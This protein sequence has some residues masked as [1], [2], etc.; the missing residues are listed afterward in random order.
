[1]Q[2][3]ASSTVAL[4]FLQGSPQFSLDGEGMRLEYPF[5]N[6]TVILLWVSNL[7]QTPV[8]P[9]EERHD[10]NNQKKPSYAVRF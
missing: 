4:R 1:M 6:L 7:A 9:L 8:S 5:I 10:P 3:V 2:D